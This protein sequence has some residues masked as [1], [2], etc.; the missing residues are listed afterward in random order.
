MF[1]VVVIAHQSDV[2]VSAHLAAVHQCEGIL[3]IHFQ[4]SSTAYYRVR[5]K[6]MKTVG[7]ETLNLRNIH[8]LLEVC[9]QSKNVC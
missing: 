1:S 2:C 9:H 5:S 6:I 3:L 4:F 7:A 8:F